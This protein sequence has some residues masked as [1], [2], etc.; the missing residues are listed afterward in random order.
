MNFTKA[1]CRR[2]SKA[3]TR[4]KF[5]PAISNLTRS[6]LGTFAFGAALRTSSAEVQWAAFVSRYQRS[7]EAFVSG[8]LPQKPA[9]TLR[10]ITRMTSYKHVPN[11]GTRAWGRSP[12]RHVG[13]RH[14]EQ[15]PAV[16]AGD[17]RAH[18]RDALAAAH[19]AR[20]GEKFAVALIAD[21]RRVQVDRQLE[22]F[23]VAADLHFSDREQ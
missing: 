23:A 7:S 2:K 19:E 12:R 14:V 11:L 20:L 15:Q 22:A 4:R 8:C 10:A 17:A 9:S 16:G 3:T 13:R 5:P 21:E 1:I 18:H 6:R